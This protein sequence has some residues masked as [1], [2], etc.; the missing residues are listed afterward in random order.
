MANPQQITA[1]DI[2]NSRSEMISK[3]LFAFGA[4]T[5]MPAIVLVALILLIFGI[6]ILGSIMLGY[7]TLTESEL[8]NVINTGMVIFIVLGVSALIVA[9]LNDFLFSDRLVRLES[10]QGMSNGNSLQLPRSSWTRHGVCR[11]DS[12]TSRP[13]GTRWRARSRQLH[14][15]DRIYWSWI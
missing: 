12:G 5:V 3:M 13:G 9:A 11:E 15:H 1:S 2:Q 8:L 7:P 10:F 6:V 14:R 4:A